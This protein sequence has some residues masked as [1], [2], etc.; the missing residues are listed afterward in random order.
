MSTFEQREKLTDAYFVLDHAAI[1]HS[2]AYDN[3]AW[4][5]LEIAR[6]QVV[7]ELFEALETP[8]QLATLLSKASCNAYERE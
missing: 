8:L 7:T 2:C 3:A 4:K 5:V 1:D 6:T